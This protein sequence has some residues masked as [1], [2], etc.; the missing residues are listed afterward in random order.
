MPIVQLFPNFI[1]E[2]FY[3]DDEVVFLGFLRLDRLKSTNNERSEDFI[4]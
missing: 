2:R 1:D 4:T 3:I